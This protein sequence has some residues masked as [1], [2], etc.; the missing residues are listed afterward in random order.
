RRS[1]FGALEP[2]DGR[3]SLVGGGPLSHD[4]RRQAVKSQASLSRS[5]GVRNSEAARGA[6]GARFASVT[7]RC[8]VKSIK[9]N[10]KIVPPAAIELRLVR[11]RQDARFIRTETSVESRCQ[12]TPVQS[13]TRISSLI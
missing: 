2:D 5:G 7:L 4:E 13:A 8:G 1:G 3:A 11:V 9:P 12:Y 6:H 10:L